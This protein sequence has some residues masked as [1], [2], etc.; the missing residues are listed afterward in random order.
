MEGEGRGDKEIIKVCSVN[1]SMDGGEE[2]CVTC[3]KGKLS[4]RGR[5]ER[6]R[7]TDRQKE[8]ER[9]RETDRQT[10]TDREFNYG[11]ERG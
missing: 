3:Y 9:Q 4:G 10:G 1:G 2:N 8:I 11:R 7:E 6:E 5:G